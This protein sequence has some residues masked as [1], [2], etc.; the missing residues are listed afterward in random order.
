MLPKP[1]L[2]DSDSK[3]DQRTWCRSIYPTS[4]GADLFGTD[5]GKKTQVVFLLLLVNE[6]MGA[7]AS[8]RMSEN[9][10]GGQLKRVLLYLGA[11]T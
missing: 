11:A 7:K 5:D 2:S 3:I 6:Q 1:G 4:V 9:S 10:N 8:S